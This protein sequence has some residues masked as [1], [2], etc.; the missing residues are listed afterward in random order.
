MTKEEYVSNWKKENGIVEEKPIVPSEPAKEVK[1]IANEIPAPVK[2]NT[3]LS[4]EELLKILQSRNITVSSLDDLKPKPTQEELDA[5]A[6]ARQNKILAYGLETGKVKREEY[7]IF[8]QQLSKKDQ[9]AVSKFESE[10][11]K[12]SSLTEDQIQDALKDY[13]LSMLD[14]ENP[15][16][17]YRQQELEKLGEYE[18]KEK[19][20]S[21]FDLPSEYD[22]HEQSELSKAQLKRKVEAGLAVYKADLEKVIDTL[23]KEDFVIGDENGENETIS[24][25]YSEDALKELRKTLTNPDFVVSQISQGYTLENLTETASLLL[26]AKNRLGQISHAAKKYNS[27]QKEKYIQGRK[28]IVPKELA[29][30]SKAIDPNDKIAA[31]VEQTKAEI[32]AS[33]QPK[34]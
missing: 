15:A 32:A 12:D 3:E 5:Q 1:P 27:N 21:I 4:D 26:I 14:E 29:D 31:W 25:E 30:Q 20:K 10:L 34:K 17:K 8:N 22:K 28:G 13:T 19:Y 2:T 11:R 16:R 33:E 9:I 6:A 24:F 7:D 23:K 18:L